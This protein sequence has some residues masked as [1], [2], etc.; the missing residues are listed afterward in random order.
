MIIKTA[1]QLKDLTNNLSKKIGIDQRTLY[2]KYMLERLLERTTK[3]KD[4]LNKY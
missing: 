2:T 1:K 4:Y 3:N